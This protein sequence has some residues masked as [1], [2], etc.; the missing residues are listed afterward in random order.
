MMLG[1]NSHGLRGCAQKFGEA[2]GSE[3][4]VQRYGSNEN[5]NASVDTDADTRASSKYTSSQLHWAEVKMS[6]HDIGEC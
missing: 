3:V 1:H 6:K 2:M 4:S 5:I